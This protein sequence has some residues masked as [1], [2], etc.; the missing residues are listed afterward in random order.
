VPRLAVDVAEQSAPTPSLGEFRR[1]IAEDM[2]NGIS[3]HDPQDARLEQIKQKLFKQYGVSRVQ[4][5]PINF[6][7]V[8]LAEGERYGNAVMDRQYGRLW[9][10]YQRQ[11]A[12]QA[13]FG[14][15][16][17]LVALRPLS[18][19]LAGTGLAEHEHFVRHAEQFRR[20][21]IKQLTDYH[22]A[23]GTF[24]DWSFTAG[25]ELWARAPDFVYAAPGLAVALTANV[26]HFALLLGWLAVAWVG[27]LWSVRRATVEA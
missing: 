18:M 11:A 17:P 23:N 14:L 2:K 15:A 1:V 7:G 6:D 12:T 24:D 3:G 25:P 13:W 9:A 10:L 22:I 8:D 26:R 27:A 5:L 20:T 4:D 19:A 16:S 21:F